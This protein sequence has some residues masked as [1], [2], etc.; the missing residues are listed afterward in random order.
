VPISTS[1][2]LPPPISSR[3]FTDFCN[4]ISPPPPIQAAPRT[5]ARPVSIMI[6]AI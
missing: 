4:E 1:G 3:K 5:E 2:I 6:A